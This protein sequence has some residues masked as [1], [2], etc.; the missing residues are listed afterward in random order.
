[1]IFIEYGTEIVHE[2]WAHKGKDALKDSND[3]T[4]VKQAY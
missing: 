2:N 4:R 3:G 1:M